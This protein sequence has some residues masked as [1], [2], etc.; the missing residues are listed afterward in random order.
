MSAIFTG[1]CTFLGQ[2]QRASRKVGGL[3]WIY[4]RNQWKLNENQMEKSAIELKVP[5]IYDNQQ[6]EWNAT[7]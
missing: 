6:N 7:V 4:G 5:L 3:D 1:N 2:L